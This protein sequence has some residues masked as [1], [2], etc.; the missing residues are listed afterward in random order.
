MNEQQRKDKLSQ[1]KRDLNAVLNTPEGQRVLFEVVSRCGVFQK[2]FTGNSETF[3]REG[4]RVI[5][6]SVI[7]DIQ[8]H[9]PEKLAPFL[10]LYAKKE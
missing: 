7:D 10:T 2:S 6:L 5:G 1:Y 8:V 9:A 4:K 3:F